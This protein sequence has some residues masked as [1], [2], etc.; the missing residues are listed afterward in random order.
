M[1]DVMQIIEQR[2]ERWRD[3]VRALESA[4][5]PGDVIV[6]TPAYTVHALNRYYRGKLPVIPASGADWPAALA[7]RR[8]RRVWL[9]ELESRV[10]RPDGAVAAW[11]RRQAPAA[12]PPPP[13]HVFRGFTTFETAITVRPFPCRWAAGR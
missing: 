10:A 2:K 8:P 6:A 1:A 4:A 7:V 9:V 11:L 12:A 13:P 3:A 5:L